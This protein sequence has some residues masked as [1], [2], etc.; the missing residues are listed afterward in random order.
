MFGM[1]G[2]GLLS[3]GVALSDVRRASVRQSVDMYYQFSQ[4][5]D[6]RHADKSVDRPEKPDCDPEKKR[7]ACSRRD[8]RRRGA[9][10]S[11]R[12]DDREK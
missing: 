10:N 11:R 5:T 8:A 9:D 3:S 4:N 1:C 12:E 7:A 2:N 6:H